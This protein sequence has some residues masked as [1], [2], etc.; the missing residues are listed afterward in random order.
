M[1]LK[2]CGI[3]TQEMLDFCESNNVDY[4]G[5]NFVPWSKRKLQN[6]DL[7][8][9]KLRNSKK[10]ALFMDQPF[11]AVLDLLEKFEFDAIQLHGQEPVNYLQQIKQ[12]FPKLKLWKA[13][14][15]DEN[16]ETELLKNY[17]DISDAFLFDGQNPG[18]GQNISDFSKLQE[19][20]EFSEKSNI[21]Y[22]IAGGIN[23]ENIELF[24]QNF[25]KALFLDTASG[26]EKNKKFSIKVAQKL[27]DNF[28][29]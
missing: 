27:I 23:A 14:T 22:G 15:L 21:L 10:V 12:S 16:F 4:V 18:G 11:E 29:K 19:A 8:K 1:K 20:I 6:F 24:K 25:P 5:F 17:S 13:F 9:Q 2:I 28:R 26:V 7:L 3:R